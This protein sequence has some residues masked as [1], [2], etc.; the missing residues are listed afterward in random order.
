M[1]Q[2]E[3]EHQPAEDYEPLEPAQQKIS[4]RLIGILGS[5]SVLT[6]VA[7]FVLMLVPLPTPGSTTNEGEKK[8]PAATSSI[9]EEVQQEVQGIIKG[10]IAKEV[11]ISDIKDDGKVYRIDIELL[12]KPES[13]DPVKKWTKIVCQQCSGIFEKHNIKMDIRVEASHSKEIYGRTYYSQKTG[14]FEFTKGEDIK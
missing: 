5:I 8:P 10:D 2:P 7:I 6:F 3:E 13:Y 1:E 11:K 12:S 9:P 4:L 14:K